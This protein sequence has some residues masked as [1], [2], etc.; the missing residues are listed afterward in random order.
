[1]SDDTRA[2]LGPQ[3]DTVPAPAEPARD[4]EPE[5]EPERYRL[6]SELGRG[7]MGRV[8]EAFDT[9]LHRVVALKEVLPKAGASAERRF[10]REVRITAR[11]EHAA[12]VPLYDAGKTEDGR[13]FYVMRKV[14]GKPFDQLIAGAHELTERLALLP[15]LL[16]AIDAI[17]HAHSRGVIHRDLKPQNILVGELGETVVI[18]WGLAKVIGEDDDSQEPHV[19]NAADSLQTQVG[20]VFGTPGFMSPEQA[21]G[22]DL[23]PRSD[24]FAL[25]A[26]LYTLLAGRP[27]VT[28]KSATEMIEATHK[29]AIAPVAQV[30][31]GA[32]AE[33]VA[34][35]DK[36][37]A[38]EASA[39]YQNAAALAED[40]RRFLTGQLVAAHRYT[41]VERLVRFVRRHRAVLSVAALGAATV[42]VLAWVGVHRIVRERDAANAAEAHAQAEKREV[43]AANAK[44]EDNADQLRV[45]QARLLVAQNPTQALALLKHVRPEFGRLDDARAVAQAAVAR[46]VAWALEIG[47][48]PMIAAQLSPDGALLVT[49]DVLGELRVYDLEVRRMA[50]SKKLTRGARGAWV[51]DGKRLLVFGTDKPA[52]LLEPRDGSAVPATLPVMRFAE[53]TEHGDRAVYYDDARAAGVLDLATQQV[54]ALS[55]AH[56]GEL[57]ISPDGSWLAVADD[58]RLAVLD[59]DGR[60][61]AHEDGRGMIVAAA[62]RRLATLNNDRVRELVLDPQPVWTDLAVPLQPKHHVL[63]IEYRGDDLPRVKDPRGPASEPELVVSTSAGDLYVHT[64]NAMQRRNVDPQLIWRTVPVRDVLMAIGEDGKL[65]YTSGMS[66]GAVALPTALANPRIV[67]RPGQSRFAVV[68]PG[69]L[70]VYDADDFLPRRLDAPARQVAFV[71]DDLIVVH[72]QAPDWSWYD[73]AAGKP[74]DAPV[75]EWGW[76]MAFLLD[77]DGAE[78][79]VLRAIET[80]NDGKSHLSVM[81]PGKPDRELA[82]VDSE[83]FR[84]MS[85]PPRIAAFVPGDAVVWGDGARVMAQIGDAP[86]REITKLDGE[87]IAVTGLGRLRFAALSA[88][89]E[90]ARGGLAGSDLER[91]H[92][93]V[94]GFAHLAIDRDGHVVIGAGR[95]LFV[96]GSDVRRLAQLPQAI[97]SIAI[98]EGGI[99]AVQANEVDIVPPTGAPKRVLGHVTPAASRDGHLLVA[100]GNGSQIELL[101]LPAQAR[102]TLPWLYGGAFSGLAVSPSARRIV[103]ATGQALA[104]WKLPDARGSL[105]DWLAERTN[106]CITQ[107]GIAWPWEHACP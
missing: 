2:S 97:D 100:T 90:L 56:A 35:V 87:V 53:L 65:H 20:S 80:Q 1:M 22:D 15:N 58:K 94:H 4:T 72:H 13:P 63:Q 29:H 99:A 101:E 57:A 77:V 43:D 55:I 37:L 28:G 27:P 69:A 84:T 44:L 34:I 76:G 36:A 83:F 11:L 10:E 105:G 51:D 102:W 54:H 38:F 79:R 91:A 106:A 23:G 88:R 14:S 103:Q 98:V 92:A 62:R 82:V 47:P 12:I 39:R 21:R 19:P 95:D 33:L 71:D 3:A 107:D 24:V 74:I 45:D 50:W 17:A 52:Q 7:G 25:G 6:G 81:R 9:Q 78:R 64:G 31:P 104:L 60:E 85:I 30:C 46:G 75:P 66:A 89:G 26:T 48:E 86:P 16:A 42:A 8:V 68:G 67:G 73:L 41:R 40:V 49:A 32:P 18:D 93:D 96:W 5:I 61:V 59:S 70:F